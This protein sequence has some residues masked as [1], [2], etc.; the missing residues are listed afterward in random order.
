MN[1]CLYTTIIKDQFPYMWI[2]TAYMKTKWTEF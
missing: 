1:V 2:V